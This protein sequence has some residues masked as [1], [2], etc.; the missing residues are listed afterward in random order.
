M[1]LDDFRVYFYLAPPVED[2]SSK[3]LYKPQLLALAEGLRQ[4]NISF[5]SNINWWK[6][7]DGDYLFKK[8]SESY[9][10]FTCV[11]LGSEI[12]KTGVP[13]LLYT[14]K[15]KKSHYKIIMYDWVASIFFSIMAQKRIKLIDTYFYYSYSNKIKECVKCTNVKPWPI[16]LTNRAIEYA[17]K[18]AKPF[19]ERNNFV[20]WSHRTGHPIRTHVKEHMYSKIPSCD[21]VEFHDSFDVKDLDGYDKVLWTQTGRRHNPR[22]YEALG[23][24]KIVDC[25]GGFFIIP[26]GAKGKNMHITDTVRNWDNYKL[27]EAFAAGCCV[28]TLDLDYYGVQLPHMPT[29]GEHYIGIRLDNSSLNETALRIKN[30]VLGKYNLEEIANAGKEWALKYYSPEGAANEFLEK[31]EEIE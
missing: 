9:E 27:W 15:S 21:F 13:K 29:N 31:L 18:Y 14:R 4:K 11:V 12:F 10:K 30:D 8:T 16:G 5:A 3:S 1:N 17:E 2:D 22:F 24:S 7:K 6:T 19:N 23:D 20:L 25:C 26:E 28:I